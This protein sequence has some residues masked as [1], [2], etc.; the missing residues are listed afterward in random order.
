MN[1]KENKI[2][3]LIN[4]LEDL[5]KF[6]NE[7]ERIEI[8]ASFIQIDILKEVNDFMEA[9]NISR[10]ELAKKLKKS[11][12][13]ISQL[14][15]GDKQLNLKMI[16][17]LQEILDAKF[18]PSFKDYSEYLKTKDFGKRAYIKN[19]EEEGWA[20]TEPSFDLRKYQLEKRE[21]ENKAA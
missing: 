11:K 21:E 9:K 5:F 7:A 6:E 10:T 1:A 3:S 2:E 18:V 4:E 19:I 20:Q 8:K 15:S 17:Q 12:S 14:F 13:F 16:A